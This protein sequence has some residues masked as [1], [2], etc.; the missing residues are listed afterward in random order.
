MSDHER[1]TDFL[2]Q[3]LRYENNAEHEQVGEAIARVQ[4]DER[5]V[6]RAVWLMGL[7]AGLSLA[8]VCYAAVFLADSPE[9]MTRIVTPVIV[10]AFCALGV[11]SLI[12]LLAFAGLALLYR[13]DLD[14]RREECRRLATKL[15]DSRLGKPQKTSVAG[16]P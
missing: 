12:C 15:L 16:S 9:D 5:C 13:R 3:C 6:W 1:E 11:G 8:G 7:L 10:K 4:R 14:R 2:R